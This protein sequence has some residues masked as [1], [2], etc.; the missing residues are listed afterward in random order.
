[1]IEL[2]KGLKF[3]FISSA[4]SAIVSAC[5]GLFYSFK[6]TSRVVENLYGQAVTLFG[7]GI[8]ANDSVFKAAATKGTDIAIII[9]ALALVCVILFLKDKP[10][11]AFLRCGLLSVILYTS[12]CL[13]LGV[14]FNRLF[15]LYLAQFSCSFFA[16]VVSMADLLRKKSFENSLYN[17]KLTGT[18]IFIV[19]A[20]CSVLQWLAFILPAVFSGEPMEIID[21]YTTEPTF[22]LDLAIVFPVT[23][24]CGVSL[25]KKKAVAYQLAPVI[26]TL[27]TGVAVCVICQ[28]IIQT[29][30]GIAPE[31]GQ[32]LGMVVLFV[33][34]GVIASA[35]NIRLLKRAQ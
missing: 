34:L 20:G 2:K 22:A 32:L 14:A 26:L 4:I 3:L 1:V 10:C 16:F 30:L 29:N 8:Y 33:I 19:V 13:I 11:A 28:T 5:M 35:L 12:F 24:Y 31:F 27:F 15:L 9:I 17:K 25:L 18:A 7:D 6:G 23:V 21:I